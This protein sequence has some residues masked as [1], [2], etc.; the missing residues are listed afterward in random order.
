MEPCSAVGID[1]RLPGW[2]GHLK[3]HGLADRSVDRYMESLRQF[4]TYCRYK[5]TE[6]EAV[7]WLFLEDWVRH[8]KDAGRAATTINLKLQAAGSFFEYLMRLGQIKHNPRKDVRSQKVV[9]KVP[10]Y[11]TE[12][13][14]KDILKK[15]KKKLDLA[16]LETL[17]GCGLRN[18]EVCGANVHDVLWEEAIIRVTGK[19]D[20]HRLVPIPVPC[21]KALKAWLPER[22]K[23]LEQWQRPVADALFIN[24]DGRR[25][26][27]YTMQRIVKDAAKRAG[28]DRRVYP[29][30]WRHT[31][32]THMYNNGAD[33]RALQELLGHGH[34][35]T[36]EIYTHVGYKKLSYTVKQ[37]HPRCQ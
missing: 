1:A 29:H 25:C 16:V 37:F 28:V 34:I 6:V 22:R 12:A 24:R 11:F 19:G 9:R 32:A 30:L 5:K 18:A 4:I 13:N 36:T 3:A 23:R 8:L 21:L 7:D 14:A 15:V 10:E 31:Y 33:I 35:Q 26:T 20:K 17:Y 2:V 27:E